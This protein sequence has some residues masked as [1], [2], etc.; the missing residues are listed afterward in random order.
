[1]ISAHPW[2]I[3]ISK[4]AKGMRDRH[5]EGSREERKSIGDKKNGIWRQK[6]YPIFRRQKN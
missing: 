5:E 2:D 3:G 1:L 6:K 4:R